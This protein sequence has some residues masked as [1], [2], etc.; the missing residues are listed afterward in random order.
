MKQPVGFVDKEKPDFVC[1]LRKAIYG[2]KQ[3]PKAWYTELSSFLL[4]Y[5]FTNSVSDA[6]LFIFCSKDVIIFFFVYVDDL[7]ITGNNNEV[8][9]DFLEQLS[10]RFS[11]KDLGNLNYFLGVE[12]ITT[13]TGLFLNQQKYI[14]DMLKKF[15]MTNAKEMMTPMSSSLQLKLLDGSAKAGETEY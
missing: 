2:L 14:H 9:K 1:K 8:I 7:V 10:N 15:N 3:A 11:L 6:S 5:G 4:A 12:V 13:M